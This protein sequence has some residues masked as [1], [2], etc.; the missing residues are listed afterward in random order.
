V[1]AGKKRV[2]FATLGCKVNQSET[3][4]M[5]DLFR[6]RGYQIVDFDEEADVYVV[7]TCTVTHLA[8][9]KSRQLVRRAGRRAPGAIIAVVGC[10]PQTAPRAVEELPEV[11]VIIGTRD[12]SR[13]VEYVEEAA[14]RQERINR[15]GVLDERMDFEELP[16]DYSTRTRA[17][18][19]IEDGCD[20]FCTYCIIPYARGPVRSRA[21]ERVRAAAERLAA[22]GYREIVLTGIHLGLY[23]RDL[24]HGVDLITVLKL[25]E[26]IPGLER[27]RLS[28]LDP[29][30]VTPDLLAYMAEH[31]RVCPHLHIPV[32][33]GSNA[34]LKRMGRPY[35][36]EEYLKLVE[37][38]RRVLP[39]VGLT[40]DIIVGFPGETEADFQAT[41]DLA[42][43]A[44]FSRLHVFSY[45]PRQG[46]P[47]AAMPDQ[48]DARIKDERSRRLIALGKE[49][50]LKFHGRYLGRTLE[51]LVEEEREG[52]DLAGYSGNYIRVRLSGPD[53]LMN[54]VLPVRITAVTPDYVRGELA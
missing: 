28:S 9:R 12:R 8:D 54:R 20:R 14:R 52:G 26:D 1:L 50:A 48:V 3:E 40:T 11:S 27:V 33:S 18:L 25:L 43:Q 24:G 10:W 4:A 2:A 16:L 36:R 39:D 7:N 35:T 38:I 30:E 46:T 31:A 45:S 6:E 13:I 17:Y 19:K 5:K 29:H 41:L 49:L 22:E 23:G 32:Q 15:V 51:V 47:A 44:G 21:P 42:Q 37:K 34:V 53:A